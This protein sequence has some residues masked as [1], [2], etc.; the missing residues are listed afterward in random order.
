MQY[1]KTAKT[2]ISTTWLI[3]KEGSYY[4][5]FND[6]GLLKYSNSSLS[7][8]LNSY[9]FGAK[10]AYIEKVKLM[11][12]LTLDAKIVLPNYTYLD[13]KNAVITSSMGVADSMIEAEAAA[14]YLKNIIIDGGFWNCNNNATDVVYFENGANCVYNDHKIQLLN[15]KIFDPTRHGIYI[16]C[17]FQQRYILRNI[18]ITTAVHMANAG[19]N[20]NAS[21]STLEGLNI[22]EGID[23]K[24]LIITGAANTI[25]HINANGGTIELNWRCCTLSNVWMDSNGAQP[26]L[27]LAGGG[28]V[29]SNLHLRVAGSAANHAQPAI[30]VDASADPYTIL[31]TITNVFA[32]RDLG[33]AGTNLW[34]QPIVE[35]ASLTTDKNIYTNINAYDAEGVSTLVG[36]N[37]HIQHSWDSTTWRA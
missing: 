10:Q 28:H 3:K 19:I 5:A 33:A 6:A 7:T 14:T 30:A 21:D 23:G 29:A 2:P 9:V 31:N 36:A 22:T 34:H 13:A 26:A 27:R 17:A 1:L 8:L 24:C 4:H 12:N 20:F 25:N 11:G 15:M 35:A 37:S 16:N 32:G 18:D